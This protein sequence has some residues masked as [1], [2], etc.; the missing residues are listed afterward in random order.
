MAGARSP[1]RIRLAQRT[2]R[3]LLAI[4]ADIQVVGAE[5]V[6]AHGPLIAAGNHLS[7]VDALLHPSVMP[8]LDLN[9]NCSPRATAAAPDIGLVR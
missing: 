9:R 4:G 7:Y 5:R 2:G 8:R 1:A 3:L 6:P